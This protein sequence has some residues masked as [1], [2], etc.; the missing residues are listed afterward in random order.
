MTRR[1][2]TTRMKILSIG[3]SVAAVLVGV[4]CVRAAVSHHVSA[5][6]EGSVPATDLVAAELDPVFVQRLAER[7][8]RPYRHTHDAVAQ[9]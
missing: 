8:N 6:A 3:L 1:T 9:R 4:E 5:R 7:W 2:M